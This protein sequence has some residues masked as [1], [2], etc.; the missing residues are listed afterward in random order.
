MSTLAHRATTVGDVAI[1]ELSATRPPRAT[2]VAAQLSAALRLAGTLHIVDGRDVLDIAVAHTVAA[3]RIAADITHLYGYPSELVRGRQPHP[4]V[5]RVPE[6]APALARQAGLLDRHGRPIRGLANS[7]VR[8][9][10]AELAAVWRGALITRGE[11]SSARRALVTIT[12]PTPEAAYAL[13]GIA[14]R[15][16]VPAKT[17]T[18]DSDGPT[19]VLVRGHAEIAALL[20]LLGT[21]ATRQR[22][23]TDHH[24]A[25]R[26]ASNIDGFD[27][28]NKRR[29]TVSAEITAA[30]A[31]RALDILGDQV[32]TDLRYAGELR[33]AH[34]VISLDDLGR[35]AQPPISKDTI[36]GR[37]RR[38]LVA[39]DTAA[40]TRGIPD[41]HSAVPAEL[42]DG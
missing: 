7:L 37:I 29:A 12:C 26:A 22:W 35:H 2:A 33:I 3:R 1:R 10:G 5:V 9:T 42:L 41:T 40:R 36:A 38:L 32:A 31:R 17:T 34:P 14:R 20:D 8:G 39:A 18:T 23:L 13:C 15:I 4:V 27:N 11:L 30:R 16:G 21:P 25:P 28:S 24:P 6:H 19:K